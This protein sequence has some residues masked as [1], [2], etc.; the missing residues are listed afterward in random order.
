MVLENKSHADC[1]CRK[2][3]LGSSTNIDEEEARTGE[4][5]RILYEMGPSEIFE[6][7]DLEEAEFHKG[8]VFV[9]RDGKKHSSSN[10][11]YLRG[12]NHRSESCTIIPFLHVISLLNSTKFTHFL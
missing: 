6:V 5:G 11:G 8:I 7:N 9:R 3:L 4:A 2:N 12:V 10:R 1:L